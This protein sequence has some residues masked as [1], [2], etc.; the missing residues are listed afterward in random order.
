MR[1]NNA[2]SLFYVKD[3]TQKSLCYILTRK[4]ILVDLGKSELVE[5]EKLDLEKSCISCYKKYLQPLILG[6]FNVNIGINMI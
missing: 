6:G 4:S 2:K 3:V 1:K 5:S